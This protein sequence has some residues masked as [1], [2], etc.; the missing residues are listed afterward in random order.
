MALLDIKTKECT[1]IKYSPRLS[2]TLNIESD[3]DRILDLLIKSLIAEEY[4]EEFKR[5]MKPDN[6]VIRMKKKRILS[7]IFTRIRKMHGILRI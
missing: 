6:I 5:F 7:L 2:D 1:P 3:G 4:K